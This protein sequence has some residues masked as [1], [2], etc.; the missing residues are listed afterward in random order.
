MPKKFFLKT[1]RKNSNF[2]LWNKVD[3]LQHEDTLT[4]YTWS[5]TQWI[6]FNYYF[7]LQNKNFFFYSHSF[8][9]PKQ[10]RTK[11]NYHEKNW[12]WKFIILLC[13]SY[14]NRSKKQIYEFSVYWTMRNW[15]NNKNV[16]EFFCI[17]CSEEADSNRESINTL[18]WFSSSVDVKLIRSLA[19]PIWLT[20]LKGKNFIFFI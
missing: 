10:K 4:R 8:F 16:R 3:A 17:Q 19:N 18:K 9:T 6:S 20:I 11:K 12:K 13:R 7:L 14:F 5:K 1:F 15:G 2:L